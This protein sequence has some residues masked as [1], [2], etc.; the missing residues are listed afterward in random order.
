MLSLFGKIYLFICVNCV[1]MD[2][3]FEILMLKEIET[4]P[5]LKKKPQTQHPPPHPSKN[6]QN[7]LLYSLANDK[8]MSLGLMIYSL[9]MNIA[10]LV[11]DE[12]TALKIHRHSTQ[13]KHT[14]R[15]VKEEA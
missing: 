10:N 7:P 9:L 6:H 15:E 2:H 14:V 3:K 5:T 12:V 11:K 13:T 1:W 4:V 8:I